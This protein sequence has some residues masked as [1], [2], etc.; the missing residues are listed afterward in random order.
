LNPRP[1]S[2]DYES[3]GRT[4]ESFRARHFLQASLKTSRLHYLGPCFGVCRALLLRDLA[5]IRVQAP[6]KVQ[7]KTAGG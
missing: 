2:G 3:E 7:E 1:Y 5:T 6:A 4:F